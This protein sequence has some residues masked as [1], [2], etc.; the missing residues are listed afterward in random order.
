MTAERN[1][2]YLSVRIQQTGPIPLNVEFSCQ[3]HELIVLVG[4][5]GSGK[6]TLLRSIAGLYQ[7]VH[8]DITCAGETWSDATQHRPPQRRRTGLVFQHYALF[9][10]LTVTGNIALACRD[11]REPEKKSYIRDMLLLVN[12]EGLEERYPSQLSGGQQQRV[13]LAR[14]LAREPAILLLDEPFSAVDQVTRRK[15]KQ[16]L[17]YL[18]SKLN[19][20]IILVTHDL[21][22]ARML[23]D[24]IC[25]LHNGT[26]LQTG[27]PETV[28]SKPSNAEVAR[29]VD[30]TNIFS[31]K[32]IRHDGAKQLTYLKWNNY[33]LECLLCDEYSPGTAV[34]WVIPADS[35]ILHRRDRPSR[36]ERE[37]PVNGMIEQ[38][39]PLGENTSIVMKVNGCAEDLNFSIPTHTARRNNLA[40]GSEISISLLANAIHIMPKIN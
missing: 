40:E 2:D 25:V 10:H 27:K 21:D 34:D 8:C 39:I 13:A 37:N 14:A 30:M 31:G 4:P 9:P 18:R 16:E 32:I 38:F 17:V 20:P 11:R 3:Q 36:G 12:L 22:E 24:R 7:P 15:L 1:T 19:I 6:T 35:I 28:M 29:L 33:E 5:S 26:T 23:A